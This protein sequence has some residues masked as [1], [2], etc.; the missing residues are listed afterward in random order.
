MS[1]FPHRIMKYKK[2]KSNMLQRSKMPQLIESLDRIYF[3]R[4]IAFGLL[5]QIYEATSSRY[6]KRCTN[7]LTLNIEHIIE[8]DKKCIISDMYFS[9][10]ENKFTANMTIERLKDSSFFVN[11]FTDQKPFLKR[12][13]LFEFSVET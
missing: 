4:I 8:K 2:I 3:D 11:I 6:F 13:Y 10:N 1:I 5:F 9:S 12:R 7:G